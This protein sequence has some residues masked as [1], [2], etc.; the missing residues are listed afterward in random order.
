[1]T[2]TRLGKALF[3]N[4]TS[5]C[6]RWI[7]KIEEPCRAL[8]GVNKAC[9]SSETQPLP[10]D[11]LKHLWLIDFERGGNLVPVLWLL[12]NGGARYTTAR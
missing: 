3:R 5:E 12:K 6:D 9:A 2:L 1:M 8:A 7:V 11:D 4:V 10:K